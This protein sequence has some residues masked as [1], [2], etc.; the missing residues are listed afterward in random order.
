M[1]KNNHPPFVGFRTSRDWTADDVAVLASSVSGIYNA[2]LVFRI[3]RR[4]QEDQR[5]EMRSAIE[6]QLRHFHEYVDS[7]EEEVFLELW[8]K[9]FKRW[10]MMRSS[11]PLS[12]PFPLPGVPQQPEL[13]LP[14]VAQLHSEISRFAS[15][16][17]RLRVYRI[18]VASPGGFSF[19]GL[20][21]V[22]R[23]LRELLKD[24][25]YRNKQEK[26]FG[27]LEIIDKHISMLHRH[28]MVY[29]PPEAIFAD[30]RL[31]DAVRQYVENLKELEDSGKLK[32]IPENLDHVPE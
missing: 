20:G 19:T 7:H 10:E 29:L 27:Q 4:L 16:D 25:W 18:N 9:S 13:P 31:A 30:K 1:A 3:Q 22:V 6:Q 17:D 32:S 11:L 28:G 8:R 15:H 14:N 21:E 26:V 2:F 23:E 12:L 24:L 5:G